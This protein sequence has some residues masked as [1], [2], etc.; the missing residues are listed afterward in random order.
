MAKIDFSGLDEYAEKL[1]ALGAKMER[2]IIGKAVYEGAAIAHSELN[3]EISLLP[4]DNHY[5]TPSHPQRGPNSVQK[6][7][8]HRGLGISHMR[9]DDGFFNVKIGFDGYN[10]IKTRRWPNGQ[11]NVMIA[12]AIV[13]GKSWLLPTKFVS[14]AVSRCEK[15]VRGV[16]QTT[17]EKEIYDFMRGKE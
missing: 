15:K 16:M 9:N 2:D 17:V 11:P 12:R 14:K 3:S 7:G 5:G 8:L 13:R 1:A 4:T 10:D 6:A